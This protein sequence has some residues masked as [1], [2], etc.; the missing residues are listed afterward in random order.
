MACKYPTR[1][2][3]RK[4]PF[5]MMG[6]PALR[7]FKMMRGPLPDRRNL[8]NACSLYVGQS[9]T[10]YGVYF[11]TGIMIHILQTVPLHQCGIFT[12][13]H[14]ATIDHKHTHCTCRMLQVMATGTAL[15]EL[16]YHLRLVAV[17]VVRDHCDNVA[18][19]GG[20]PKGP[21]LRRSVTPRYDLGEI[22]RWPHPPAAAQ[23]AT[24]NPHPHRKI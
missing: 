8:N 6:T 11:V 22:G 15:D 24:I 1:P 23:A 19:R 21:L 9:T 12:S 3:K 5:K 7:Q 10:G 13:E 17:L 14:S 2:I 4:G 18:S 20:P 16:P